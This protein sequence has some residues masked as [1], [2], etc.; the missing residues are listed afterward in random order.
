MT[1]P[2]KVLER[3]AD[4]LNE[5]VETGSRRLRSGLTAA[6]EG[7]QATIERTN[8]AVDSRASRLQKRVT[9]GAHRTQ[10]LVNGAIETA[11]SKLE[12][13]KQGLSTAKTEVQRFSKEH[14]GRFFLV[15]VGLGTIAGALFGR[16]GRRPA[17]SHAPAVD[18]NEIVPPA[19]EDSGRPSSKA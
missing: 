12:D 2:A 16:F 4:A 3:T 8:E 19:G 14:P 18:W 9:A 1:Q 10:A 15:G 17:K 13:A 11:G 5:T 6:G 7:M